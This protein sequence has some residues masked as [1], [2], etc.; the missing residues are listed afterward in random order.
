MI[1]ISSYDDFFTAFDSVIQ[2]F[3]VQ[4]NIFLN[5]IYGKMQWNYLFFCALLPVVLSFVFDI[6]MS[7]ILSVRLREIRFFNCISARSWRLLGDSKNRVNSSDVRLK[8][9]NASLRFTRFNSVLLLK[10]K[11]YKS[12][13]IIRCKDGFRATYL[14]MRFVDNDYYY[15]YKTQNGIYYSVLNPKQFVNSSGLQRIEN[16]VKSVTKSDERGSNNG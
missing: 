9:F 7:F 14:G 15:A 11:K 4:T 6:V 5:T 3:R 10:F 13:D 8:P 2:F 1:F 12:G 16:T